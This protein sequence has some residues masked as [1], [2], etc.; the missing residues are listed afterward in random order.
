MIPKSA[1]R[2]FL[3]RERND[4]SWYKDLTDE[5]LAARCAKLPVRPPIWNKLKRHQ[6]QG[7]LLGIRLRRLAY[8]YSTGTGKTLMVLALLR[9]FQAKGK[10]HRALVLV[11]NLSNKAEWAQEIEKHT[12]RLTYR[13]L[14]GPL[15]GRWDALLAGK[16]AVYLDTYAGF[17][18][19]MSMPHPKKRIGGLTVDH[20][21]V[22]ELG[23][24][25][26]MIVCDE[27]SQGGLGN[28]NSM[29]YRIMRKLSH[30]NPNALV[31][32]LNGTPFGKD[33][34]PLWPQMFVVDKGETLG[35]SLG[36]FREGLYT[37]VEGKFTKE[38]VFE[39]ASAGK[40]HNMLKHRSLHYQADEA[41]LPAV[42]RI[43]K[44]V[45]MGREAELVY[46]KA[47]ASLRAARGNVQALK[48]EFLRM[49]Q[50]SSG[51]LGYKDDEAGKSAQLEF[52][53]KPKL[54]LLLSLLSSVVDQHKAV[55]FNEYTFSGSMICRELKKLGIKHARIYGGTKDVAA[56]LR[57]FTKDES[58][59]V[60]VVN[61]QAGGLGLN[62]QVA[63]YC[64]YF[65]SPCSP[66]V[67]IQSEARVHRQGSAHD[68]VYIYDLVASDVDLALLAMHKE[69]RSLL[70]AI[71]KGEKVL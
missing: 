38:W 68:R 5:E 67:R 64:I 71:L 32:L 18:R 36:L 62:L 31:A 13:V 15:Q 58:C 46:N 6:K 16:E 55:V 39:P 43:T 41:D 65:E 2:A 54:E 49:R 44:N 19:L 37:E 8:W 28:H 27:S 21:K 12:S 60:L 3:K 59:R 57:A 34:T 20:D 22:E 61:H 33:P 11:P 53:Y 1:I 40:L 14:D 24:L 25:L 51:F 10:L 7:L 30:L 69:G 42:V 47:L 4:W 9:Y 52:P 17:A 56:E 50:L 70:D 63:K 23:P 35:E 26:D 48:N 66:R 45:G 29:T